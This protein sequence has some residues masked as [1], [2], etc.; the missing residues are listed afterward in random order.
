MK[1]RF[2][3]ITIHRDY[4]LAS[5]SHGNGQV[6][7]SDTLL[8]RI[9]GTGEEQRMQRLFQTGKLNAGTQ[10]LVSLGSSTMWIG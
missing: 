2:T 5:L 10:T 7:Y 9:V 3:Q 4:T 6:R 1:L 8:W